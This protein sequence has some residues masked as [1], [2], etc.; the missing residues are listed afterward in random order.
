MPDNGVLA[1]GGDLVRG[2]PGGDLFL[3][4]PEALSASDTRCGVCDFAHRDHDSTADF[5]DLLRLPAIGTGP[6]QTR[7]GASS[8]IRGS[9]CC[10][11]RPA[12]G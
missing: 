5:N 9:T 2:G 4:L 11:G 3:V 12:R 10:R 7:T 8:S 1:D 6:T